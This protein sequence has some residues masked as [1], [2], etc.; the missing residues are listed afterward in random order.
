MRHWVDFAAVKRAVSLA[1][2]LDDYQ[3]PGLRR[4]RDQLQGRCPIHGGQRPDSF[5][6]SLSQTVFHCFACQATGSVLDFV[7]AMEKCSLRQA[8]LRLQQRFGLGTPA[9]AVP[10]PAGLGARHPQPQEE[11]PLVRK[12]QRDNPPLPFALTGIDPSHPYLA[13]RGI[14]PATAA[15]FGVG[16]YAGPGLLSGRIA[17]PI[18]N[19]RGQTVAYAGR[20]LDGRPPKYKLPLG[21]RKAAELFNLHRAV[22][23]GSPT[24]IL[25][26]GYFDCLR[27]HQAG[28]PWVVALMGSSLGSE[29]ERLLLPRFQRVVLLL[30]GDAAGRAASRA[31][32]A[33][34]SGKFLVTVIQ[35]PDRAQPDQLPLAALRR[36]LDDLQT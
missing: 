10:P 15:V 3:V 8:A 31:I 28:L 6:V 20:A 25:V 29:Q 4:N 11:R 34:L 18:S 23:T 27:V 2:V 13:G 30:D 5:R 17:I 19:A 33:R 21:F 32:G 26:E 1:A 36:L 24:V 22:A 35:L 7:A 12:Q 14:D 9:E 16:F